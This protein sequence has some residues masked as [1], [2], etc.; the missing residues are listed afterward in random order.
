MVQS[1]CYAFMASHGYKLLIDV[2]TTK[3]LVRYNN[4]YKICKPC[5]I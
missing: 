1:E 3:L 5:N 2:G 4:K